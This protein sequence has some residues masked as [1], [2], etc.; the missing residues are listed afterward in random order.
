MQGLEQSGRVITFGDG[1]SRQQLWRGEK[2]VYKASMFGGGEKVLW[3][4]SALGGGEDI[5]WK[6]GKPCLLWWGTP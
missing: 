6:S 2:V 5:V 4:V 3:V 1:E